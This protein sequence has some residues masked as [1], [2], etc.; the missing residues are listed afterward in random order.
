MDHKTPLE[1]ATELILTAYGSLD[2]P[3]FGK[4]KK[5]ALNLVYTPLL[6]KLKAHFELNEITDHNQDV[7]LVFDVDTKAGI[8]AI[9]FGLSLIG[10]FAHIEPVTEKLDSKKAIALRKIL[11]DFGVDVLEE[12]FLETPIRMR[13][14]YTDSEDVCL[15]NALFSDIRPPW[16]Q[17]KDPRKAGSGP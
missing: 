2:A 11:A 12:S 6:D 10:P 9:R 15:Y 17:V 1:E 5:N 13:M 16:L 7:A 4:A 8:P 3:N 14:N